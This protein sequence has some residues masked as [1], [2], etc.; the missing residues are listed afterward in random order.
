MFSGHDTN[1]AP[2]LAF[3]NISSADCIEDKWQNSTK[4]YLNCEPG[5][6]FAANIVLEFYTGSETTVKIAYNGKYVNLC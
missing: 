6:D 4:K 1:V 2:T 5:P 3:L